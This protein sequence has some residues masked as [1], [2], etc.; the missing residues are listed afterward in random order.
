MRS[1]RD[2]RSHL[3]IDED[4][5][6]RLTLAQRVHA[7]Q[8]T[9]E[10]VSNALRHGAANRITVALRRPGEFVEFEIVDDG[11]GF[12]AA[13]GTSQGTGLANFQQRAKELG[14][15]LT[16]HSEPGRGARVKLVFPLILL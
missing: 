4:V 8:I 6:R 11:A 5:A 3:N 7:L 2:F 12:D 13:A 14:A 10:A 9:R 15:E 1:H 16:M